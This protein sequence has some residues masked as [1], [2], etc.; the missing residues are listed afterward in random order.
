MPFLTVGPHD[1]PVD[2]YYTVHQPAEGVAARSNVLCVMGFLMEGHNWDQQVEYLT[3]Q[4]HCVAVYDNRGV[5]RSDHPSGRYTTRMMAEDA[6]S[7]LKHLL[8]A[9]HSTHLLGISMGGMISL[10]LIA[11]LAEGRFSDAFPDIRDR[12][13][14]SVSLMVTQAAGAVKTMMGLPPITKAGAAMIS[15]FVSASERAEAAGTV[16]FRP[17][18]FYGKAKD[19]NGVV[20]VD[21]NGKPRRNFQVMVERSNMHEQAKVDDG[22]MGPSYSVAGIFGQIMAIST[23]HVSRERL[24]RVALLEAPM[25]IVSVSHDNLVRPRN[26]YILAKGPL[27]PA[28]YEHLH[29]KDAGHAVTIESVH[30]VNDAIG[31]VTAEAEANA[32]LTPPS[33]VLAARL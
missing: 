4:G 11:S 29:L 30:E 27:A 10:E 24:A 5:G 7:M 31:R 15:P 26:Q 12:R 3:G 21:E 6:I 23:H 28:V 13:V 8:W 17:S 25:L 9:P 22:F 1:N 2:L 16:A 19:K 18:W 20:Q 32:L 33:V 14:L